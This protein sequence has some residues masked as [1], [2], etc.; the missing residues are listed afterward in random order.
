MKRICILILLSFLFQKNKAQHTL[1]A[2][3]NPVMGDMESY[4]AL[5]TNGLFLGSSGSS[6]TWNYTGIS[7][8]TNAAYSYTYVAMS[9]VPNNSLYPTGTIASDV[10]IGGIHYVYSNTST[11][12]EWLGA[13]QPTPSNCGI[14]SDPSMSYTLPFMYSSS[15]SDTFYQTNPTTWSGTT[16]VNGDG[17]GTLQL[18]SGNYSN[19]LK[20][21]F[22]SSQIGSS[23]TITSVENRY[24]SA[25]S[26]FPLL[27]IGSLTS[28]V[29]G[30]MK[31]GRLNTSFALGVL[32]SLDSNK[33]NVF[34]NPVTNGE[35]FVKLGN[36]KPIIGIEIINVLGQEVI[37]LQ[38][39]EIN[40]TET[41]RIDVSSLAKGMYYL[42][43]STSGASSAKKILIE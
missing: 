12:I 41:E 20:L 42:I 22:F 36:S 6:Q 39:N 9:S 3:F 26:K 10:G 28:S 31:Y 19:I 18:P 13:A 2:A 14:Y 30:I 32:S 17:A 25:L 8:G 23:Q 40:G 27:S 43:I 7:T 21:T 35:L 34:P 37:R 29:S 5:D 33:P 38:P 4:I 1:T 15:F 16:T 11:K 24:Y